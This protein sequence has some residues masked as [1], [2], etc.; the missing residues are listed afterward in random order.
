MGI[1]AHESVAQPQALPEIQ[2]DGDNLLMHPTTRSQA[3]IA[4]DVQGSN[5]YTDGTVPA[6]LY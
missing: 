2:L 4:C 5:S 1:Q 3:V 6:S